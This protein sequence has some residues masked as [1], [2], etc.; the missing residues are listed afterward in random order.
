MDEQKLKAR[1]FFD[2]FFFRWEEFFPP[3]NTG[4]IWEV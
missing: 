2:I 3:K 4:Q 1:I